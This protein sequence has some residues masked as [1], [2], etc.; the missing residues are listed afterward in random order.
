MILNAFCFY[1]IMQTMRRFS[2]SISHHTQF[3]DNGS[4][5]W[6][7]DWQT[8]SSE[9]VLRRHL[10]SLRW[11]NWIAACHHCVVS[12]FCLVSSLLITS[13]FCVLPVLCSSFYTFPIFSFFLLNSSFLHSARFFWLPCFS[14]SVSFLF[15]CI[16]SFC[17]LGFLLSTILFVFSLII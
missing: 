10:W 6:G 4:F 13:F 17:Y 12:T 1:V 3:K 16:V 8:G 7:D 9:V 5:L 2:L 14:F 15:I 11:T